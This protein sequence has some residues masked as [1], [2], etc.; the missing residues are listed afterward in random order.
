LYSVGGI[1]AT[2]LVALCLFWLGAID[3]IGYI[4]QEYKFL[5]IENISVSI[6][7]FG[8]GFAGHA[9][10]PNIYSSMKEP[11]KFPLVLFIRLAQNPSIFRF[12]SP[13]KRNRNLELCNKP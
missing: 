11:S 12:F 2:I 8:F 1:F 10:F 6:G 7:L 3:H 4:N 5:D 9:V 13:L